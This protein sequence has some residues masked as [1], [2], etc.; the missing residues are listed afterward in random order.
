M[1]SYL[2]DTTLVRL[3]TPS[4]RGPANLE[5]WYGILGRMLRDN[6]D[7]DGSIEAYRDLVRHRPRD[8]AAHYNLAFTL[9]MKGDLDGSI[10]AYRE[11]LRI[12]PDYVIAYQ[13]LGLALSRRGDLGG[14]MREY[15]EALR[16]DPGYVPAHYALGLALSDT[17]T[18]TALLRN[19]AK[20]CASTPITWMPAT[21][22]D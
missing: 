8:E 5:R 7:L 4:Q 2:W 9:N 19:T 14:A 3:G 21:P 18:P 13:A 15:R 11:L 6:G 22:W 16:V 1:Y 12:D 17:A 10:E 20:H